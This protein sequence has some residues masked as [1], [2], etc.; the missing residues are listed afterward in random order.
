MKVGVIALQGAVSEHIEA[1]KRAFLEMDVKGE[2]IQV[3]GKREL[4]EVQGLIIPGGE[5]T[6]ISRLIEK[7]GLSQ[8]IKDKAFAKMPIMGTCAGCILL[9]KEGDLEV[10]KTDTNLLGL[11]DMKVARNAFG[12]QRESFETKLEIK[13]FDSPYKAVFIRAPAIEKIWSECETLATFE[14]KIV[15][16]RQDNLIA[17]AF[18]PEL[19]NDTRV[20]KLLLNMIMNVDF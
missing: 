2:A 8:M 15:L 17:A 18:H 7:S 10:N 14:D 4:K 16:A 12:R 13:G 11:M 3:K 5:S 19:T 20:H 9:A 1:V 6:T